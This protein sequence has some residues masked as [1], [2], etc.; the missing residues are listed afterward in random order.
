[1]WI[2]GISGARKQE[3]LTFLLGLSDCMLGA[4]GE[5]GAILE[6]LLGN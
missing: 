1:L 3:S 2:S 6:M 4:P 5:V